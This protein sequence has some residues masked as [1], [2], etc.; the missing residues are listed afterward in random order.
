MP[1]RPL[2]FL[3]ALAL[4]AAA[5]AVHAGAPC[6]A[7]SFAP[8]DARAVAAVRGAIAQACPC[9]AYDGSAPD[10]THGRYVRCAKAVVAD[11]LDGTPLLGRFTLRRECRSEVMRLQTGSTCGY[12]PVEQRVVCCEAKPA[13]GKT[14][15]RV[16]ERATCVGSANGQVLRTACLASPFPD[17]CSGDATPACRSISAQTTLE[18]ASAAEPANTPGS[19]GVTPTNPKLLAQ[20]GG[21]GFSLNNARYT[22]WR[23]AGPQPQPDAILVLVPGFEGGAGDF[24]LLAENVLAR[25]DAAGLVLEVWGVDRRTNQLED[26]VGLE[27]AEQFLAPE[28]GLDWLFG[29]ELGLTLHPVLAAGPNRRAVFYDPQGDVPFLAGWTNLVFS[30]DIDAVVAAARGIARNQNVFLGGHSAGTGFAARYAATDFD[31]SGAGPADPGYARLRGLVLLEGGGGSV[32]AT[33]PSADT[34]DRIAAKFDG[35]LYGAV[36]DN[37]ARCVDG[38][39]PCTIATEATD[40]VEQVP[41]KCTLPTTAYAIVPGLLN[42]RILAAVEPP[43]IQGVL[44]PDGGQ[45][46]LQVDQG[47]SGNNAIAKVPDL[48]GLALLP[49]AT[50]Y[51]GIGSFIDDDGTIA[52]LATFVATSVGAPG[53]TPPPGEL[54]TWIDATESPMPASA[55]PNNGPAPTALP[56]ARWGQEKEVTRFGRMLTTFFA[57]GTNFADIYYPNAGPSTTTVTGVCAAGFCT[58]GN[59]GAAC[60]TNGQCSQSLG[61]DSTALSVG[62]GRRDIENLTQVANIDIPVLA[63][64]GTNGLAPVPG[65]FTAFAQ[66]IGTCATPGCDGTSRVPAPATP[67]PAFPTFGGAAGGFEVVMAE[68][69]AHVDVLTAEDDANNPVVAAIVDFMDRNSD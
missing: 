9:A 42:A 35:G 67:D 43:A 22:R 26:M 31:L 39:T 5:S 4:L 1:A 50:V 3:C 24:K 36:R 20:F 11:A 13:N 27:L 62:R 32:P 56:G 19:P 21:A 52:G 2:V 69:F 47:A 37:A 48:A 55:L 65:A 38:N 41:P 45:I 51:G 17:V 40:C 25:G 68:G 29:G 7:G 10:K 53:P 59:V 34:L 23:L 63:V 16:R 57:G 54:L 15:T 58:V 18:V 30:R 46:I 60:S 64:G 28:I 8:S 12:A 66:S 6:R 61:L 14:K 44:D 33:L 49:Q